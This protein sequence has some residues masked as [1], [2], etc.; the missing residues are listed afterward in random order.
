MGLKSGSRDSAVGIATVYG[1]DGRGVGDRVF[2]G[3]RFFSI[4]VL[5]PTQPPIQWVPEALSPGFKR[6]E[7][8]ADHSIPTSV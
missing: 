2:V 1:L 6:L 4:Q 3:T 7:H 8:E 5:G